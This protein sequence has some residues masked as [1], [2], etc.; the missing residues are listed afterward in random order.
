[1]SEVFQATELFCVIRKAIDGIARVGIELG[2]TPA[3]AIQEVQYYTVIGSEVDCTAFKE[4]L[5]KVTEG[6]E[7]FYLQE[8]KGEPVPGKAVSWARL[9]ELIRE[10]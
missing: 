9:Q 5:D 8:Y 4:E 3:A 10:S 1:M 7:E 6:A 2:S